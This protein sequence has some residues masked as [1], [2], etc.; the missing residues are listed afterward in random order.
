MERDLSHI[1]AAVTLLELTRA[2]LSMRGP[3]SDPAYWKARIR[4]LTSEWPRERILER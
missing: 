3:V 2:Y 1:K 4:K